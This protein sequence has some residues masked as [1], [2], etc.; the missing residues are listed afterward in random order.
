MNQAASYLLQKFLQGRCTAEERWQVYIILDTNE[1]RILLDTLIRRREA[2]AWDYP[3][4]E[5]MAM[6][7]H[8]RQQQQAMQQ[9]IAG[10]ESSLPAPAV[11]KEKHTISWRKSLRYAAIWT[12]CI[13]LS[14]LAVRK[15]SKNRLAA[16]TEIRYVEKVNP[17]GAP[18]RHV[19]PDST[20]VYLA[21]GSRLKYPATYPKTGRDIELRGEAF[22]DVTRDERH[23]FT[24]RSGTMLTRVLGTS[25]KITAYEGQEQQVAVA[26]GKVSISAVHAEKTTELALL[27]PG[28]KITYHPATGQ[29]TAG[30]AD[31]S[32]MEQWKAGNLVFT[33]MTMGN[34]AVMLEHRYGVS[35]RF[36][37]AV[38][39]RQV[40]S[41][42]FSA[43]ESLSE[44]LDMT[45]FVGKFSYRI[46]PDGKTC[47]IQ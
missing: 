45:G 15:L 2:L 23:P 31:I 12:G 29:A 5:S 1:G 8:I 34:V 40:V 37:N 26:T 22:F 25:F 13:L 36:E 24:I 42:L 39:A 43:T 21:A 14:G 18:R 27:T 11:V 35:V 19:L 17:S 4:A 16:T 41:G 30:K 10:Y 3:L 46:S 28:H 44:V 47:T 38:I 20:V 32:S 9:R 6:Q 7:Q 33:D